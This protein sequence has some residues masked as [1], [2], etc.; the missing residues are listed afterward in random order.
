MTKPN[1]FLLDEEWLKDQYLVQMKSASQIGRELNCQ[2]ETVSKYLHKYNIKI[3][4]Q[5]E[6]ISG[7]RHPLY[8]THCSD[9]TKEQ[10][11]KSLSGE[12]NPNFGKKRPEHSKLMS[13]SGNPRFGVTISK[14][15]KQK[16][17]ATLLDTY[18]NH[19]EIKEQ[20]SISRKEY[21][22][23]NPE[24]AQIQSEKLKE[25]YKDPT[26][27]KERSDKL[28]AYYETHILTEEECKIRGDQFKTFYEEHPEARKAHSD[29]MKSGGSPS[30]RPEVG[31]KI[32]D[33]LK[34]W[35][36]THTQPEKS[37]RS[38]GGYFNKLN[39]EPVWLR[40]SYETRYAEILDEYE[41]NWDYECRA[42]HIY[43]LDTT[44]RPDFY[45]PDHNLWV[46]VKG[47]MSD[48]DKIKLTEFYNTHPNENLLLVYIDHIKELEKRIESISIQNFG[49]MLKDQV[50]LWKKEKKELIKPTK[51]KIVINKLD[52]YF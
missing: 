45:L 10:M 52:N 18:E 34:I 33:S 3:R 25:Y 36:T 7:E 44:Y 40:S 12:N 28:K 35:H 32:S 27:R 21:Y 31:K 39:I 17:I 19:P 9:K 46:E 38:N 43:T 14:E 26:H 37:F 1:K 47:Y 4:T 5:S 8:G 50:A 24:A 29:F 20:I 51:E 15:Q 30:I 23:N 13:G 11:S 22:V 2:Q 41:V 6:E 42:F 49:I 48:V 16:Q